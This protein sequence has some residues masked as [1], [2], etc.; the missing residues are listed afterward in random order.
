MGELGEH[1]S[2]RLA[3]ATVLVAGA[4]WPSAHPSAAML[5]AY[6]ADP[7][8][9]A[10]RLDFAATVRDVLEVLIAGLLARSSRRLAV[11][12]YRSACSAPLDPWLRTHWRLGGRI[13]ATAPASQ[14]MTGTVSNV[15]RLGRPG[16][17][18]SGEYVI[19]GGLSAFISTVKTI[20]AAT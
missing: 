5:A 19:P 17:P 2:F 14:T 1:D 4:V 8:L 18:V 7:E 20:T 13:I 10:M 9:A 15:G 6:Q 3:G 12:M 11:V 16:L